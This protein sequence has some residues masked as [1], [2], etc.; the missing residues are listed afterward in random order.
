MTWFGWACNGSEKLMES[1]KKERKKKRNEK[2]RTEDGD[3]NAVVADSSLAV[4]QFL[5]GIPIQRARG[6]GGA[7]ED[8]DY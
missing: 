7:R 2:K 8:R 5:E 3:L 1:S 4:M 6:G